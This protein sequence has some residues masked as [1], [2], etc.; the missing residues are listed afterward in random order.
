MCRKQQNQI[1]VY[2]FD[3]PSLEKEKII[4]VKAPKLEEYIQQELRIE[5]DLMVSFI[6]EKSVF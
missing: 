1:Y 6:D 3:T 4:N 5:G 2:I